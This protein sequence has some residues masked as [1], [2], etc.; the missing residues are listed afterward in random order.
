[1]YKNKF[2]IANPVITDP[3][4]ANAVIFLLKH[5]PKGAE[6]VILNSLKQIGMVG[7]GEM[8]KFLQKM[9]EL[10]EFKK[11]MANLQSVPL[12]AGGP[13]RTPGAYF[14][15][16]HEEFRNM[17]MPEAE[18]EKSEYDLGIPTSFGENEYGDDPN[19]E[20]I[21]KLTIMEGVY[22]GTP[23]TFS[24]IIEAGKVDEGK[25]RFYSGISGWGPGQLEREIAGGAWRIMDSDPALFFD[26]KALDKLA[27]KVEESV[28]SSWTDDRYKPSMN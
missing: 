12:Y 8:T 1:M 14:I 11:A 21:K 22:F 24:H 16:G 18:E 6:G 25:F 17:V 10:S 5:T 27:G 3:I 19:Q 28:K 23:I 9:P 20:L 26:V 4:F 13:C 15:H 7:Y 2:L